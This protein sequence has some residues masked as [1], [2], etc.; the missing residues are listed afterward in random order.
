MRILHVNKYLYRRG[1]AEGYMED[2]ARL[3]A[4]VGHVVGFWGMAHPENTHLELADTFASNVELEPVPPGVAAKAGAA[5]RMVWSRSA[6]RGIALAIERFRPDVA[7]LHNIYHQL[8]PS[9]LRPLRRS[10]VPAV[11]TAHDYKLVCPSYQLL[12]NGE[13][14]EA[15]VG[16][17]FWNAPRQRCKDGSLAASLTLAVETS[18]HAAFNSYGWI[19]AIICPSRFLRDRLTAGRLPSSRLRVVRHP[20]DVDEL[21]T[22]SVPGGDVVVAGRLSKEKA[23]DIAVRAAAELPAGVELHVAG[24]G[25]E[26]RSLEALAAQVAPGRVRFHGRLDKADLL[27]LVRSCTVALVPSRWHENQ[28]MAVLEALGS[29]VPVVATTLGGLPELIRPGV[30]GELVAPN[31]PGALAAA[32]NALLAD[33][34]RSFTM[35]AAGRARVA[36]EFS[37]DVHLRALEGIYAEV[38]AGADRDDRTEGGASARRRD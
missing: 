2:V 32:T 23:V 29:G 7:H 21:P 22:K 10:G 9:V 1:G 18:V 4:D 30:D 11:L 13:V 20:V 5:A 24:D 15:C 16:R 25:P 31:D 37:S 26:R 27:D 19:G 8:S 35:G 34:A 6:E 17:R 14:C 36:A 12:S 33:P 28:P 38:G 3:Q